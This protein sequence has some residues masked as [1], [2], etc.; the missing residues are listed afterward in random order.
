[1]KA[2]TVSDLQK[3]VDLYS[4]RPVDGEDSRNLASPDMKV[5]RLP[6]EALALAKLKE[7]VDLY[8]VSSFKRSCNPI[9]PDIISSILSGGCLRW[10]VPRWVAHQWLKH[11]NMQ[12]R[13]PS[14]LV[15]FVTLSYFLSLSFEALGSAFSVFLYIRF[16]FS[17]TQDVR[18]WCTQIRELTSLICQ[19]IHWCHHF[20]SQSI[21][22]AHLIAEGS[23]SE[24]ISNLPHYFL[25]CATKG[26]D[27]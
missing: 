22:S 14:A 1:V 20:Y 15:I 19:V 4:V 21:C 12:E 24:N 11:K 26:T 9:T 5:C 17:S 10:Y 13:Y 25:G 23:C 16:L 8:E 6:P 18:A 2:P 27:R 3:F 7:I